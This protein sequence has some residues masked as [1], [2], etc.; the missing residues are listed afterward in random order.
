[1]KARKEAE[2]AETCA[3]R[4][5]G[6]APRFHSIACRSVPVFSFDQLAGDFLWRAIRERRSRGG[7]ESQD[8]LR[9]ASGRTVSARNDRLRRRVLRL[10]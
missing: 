4:N 3:V 7:P 2:Q 5:E 9:E 6:N 10:R 8:H 1:V